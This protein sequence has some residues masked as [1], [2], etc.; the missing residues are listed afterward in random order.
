MAAAAPAGSG[1]HLF[2]DAQSFLQNAVEEAEALRR[3]VQQNDEARR[4]ELEELRREVEKERFERRDAMN[5]IRYEFEEFVHKKIDKIFQEVEQFKTAEDDD[6][7]DQ[8]AQITSIVRDMNRFKTGLV[9]V[10]ESWRELA[11]S[12]LRDPLA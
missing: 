9:D 2:G 6:C 4:A 12:L 10:Q 5:K 11:G 7:E 3:L 1:G 8:Q